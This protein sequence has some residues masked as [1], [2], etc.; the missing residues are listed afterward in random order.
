MLAIIQESLKKIN[1]QITVACL[2]SF[3]ITL[4]LI[5]SFCFYINRSVDKNTNDVVYKENTLE[6]PTKNTPADIIVF[7]STNG[8]TY[9]YSWCQ[10]ANKIKE[11]NKIFFKDE[12]E[13][14]NSGRRL[15][16]LC[17]K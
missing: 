2:V 1:S 11:E 10:G 7:A 3:Y 13:A 12:Q 8:T 17:E 14:I 16:K 5:I 4:I 6:N 15:S 9:T